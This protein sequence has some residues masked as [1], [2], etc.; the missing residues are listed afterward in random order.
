MKVVIGNLRKSDFCTPE[1]ACNVIKYSAYLQ[2]FDN[3]G[4]NKSRVNIV[5][6]DQEVEHYATYVW[7][8]YGNMGCGVFKRGVQN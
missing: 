1:D 2:E 5:Y 8:G 7:Y 3:T 6:Q 4:S